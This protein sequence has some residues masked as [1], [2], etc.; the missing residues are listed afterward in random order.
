[1]I[2]NLIVILFPIFAFALGWLISH[3]VR[4]GWWGP[5]PPPPMT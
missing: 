1:M 5:T 2:G 4:K 3:G